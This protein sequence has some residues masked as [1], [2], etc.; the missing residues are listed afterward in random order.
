MN[1]AL[2]GLLPKARRAH[3]PVTPTTLMRWHRA[4]IKRYWTHPRRSPGRP[5]TRAEIRQ[6][7]LRLAAE[8]SN[9]G[10][11]QNPR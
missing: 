1:T 5:S 3:L 7:V 11:P 9:V 6:L 2:A 4:L 10:L 8:N